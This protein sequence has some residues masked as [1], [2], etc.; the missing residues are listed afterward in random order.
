MKL[1]VSIL[2][3]TLL[4]GL[5]A[6]DSLTYKTRVLESKEV[7]I[8]TS[9]YSQEGQN[10]AVTGGI[11]TEELTD[12][13]TTITVSIPLNDD[14][15]LTIDG[16][17]SAYT[18]ASSSNLDPFDRSGASGGDPTGTPWMASSG[19][20]RGDVWGNVNGSYSHSSDDR[21]K[22]WTANLSL[23]LEYDYFSVGF[24]GGHTWLFNQKNTVIG[25]SGNVFL[26]NWNAQ[27]PTEL[28]SYL[29]ANGNL[30]NGYFSGVTIRDQAGNAID[31]NGSGAWAPYRN[32]L[33]KNTA[34]NTYSLSLSFSQILSRNAQVSIFTDLVAQHGWLANPMQRVYFG[35]RDNFFIGN[36]AD[37]PNYGSTQNTG[38]FHL[39]DDIERLPAQRLKL[40]L[41]ARLNYYINENFVARTYYRYY[42][43]NWGLTSHTASL[44]LPIKI[45]RKFTLR[46]EYRYYK[47]TAIDHFAP[48][49]EHLTSSAFY[50]SDYDLSD[51]DANHYGFGISYKDIFTKLK[52]GK[53][54]LKTFDLKYSL[55]DRSTGLKAWIVSMGAKFVMD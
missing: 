10:A 27:Y 15:I 52:L 3:L 47:Q 1:I 49:E 55:Y 7:D 33:I 44:E 36:A 16:T 25:I 2:T 31:K 35:D 22:I 51:Y 48:Y 18:S 5:A 24:G 54:G 34:R 45:S 29:E 28:D 17:V 6:Q 41:G 53:Y 26:D 11:G 19:E 4:H 8:L 13:A 46:P 20:S 21:N 32:E 9:L 30:N 37:I 40:P 50:T 38:V 39:A 12:L 43:D 14:D 42:L 23:A